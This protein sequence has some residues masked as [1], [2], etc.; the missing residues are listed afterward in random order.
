[1]LKSNQASVTATGYFDYSVAQLESLLAILFKI[2]GVVIPVQIQTDP[3]MLKDEIGKHCTYKIAFS[4]D[5]KSLVYT[6]RENGVD[7]LWEQPLSAGSAFKQLTH[8]TSDRIARFEF[9]TDGAQIAIERAHTESD[10][11]LLRD[12]GGKR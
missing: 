1:M 11:V 4:P 8:F 5:G 9:S 7:N 2:P 10:A 12:E 3:V 6:V